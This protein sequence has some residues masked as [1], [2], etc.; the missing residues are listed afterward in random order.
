[1]IEFHSR[2]KLIIGFM[3]ASFIL[4]AMAQAGSDRNTPLAGT[5]TLVSAV[6]TM[7][8]GQKIDVFFGSNPKG[9]VIFTPQGHF[10]VLFSK[11]GLPKF[12]SGARQSGTPEEN[13]AVVQGSL[14]YSGTYTVDA[15]KK[16]L[17]MN[18]DVSTFPAWIGQV[19]KREYTLE[20]DRLQWVGVVGAQGGNLIISLQRA[21]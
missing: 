21:K 18:V 10:S 16:A 11:D 20:A 2:R 7:S 15:A 5:W 9:R 4:P 12:A 8:D 19:Q 6:N 3:A 14:A 1:M 17:V 13:Q